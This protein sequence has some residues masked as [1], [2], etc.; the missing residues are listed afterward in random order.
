[1]SIAANKVDGIRCALVRSE[2]DAELARLHNNA[3]IIALGGRTTPDAVA[4][5]PS[6]S[7]VYLLKLKA[8]PCCSLFYVTS[9]GALFGAFRAAQGAYS[10]PPPVVLLGLTLPYSIV[11]KFLATQ[12]PADDS[13]A[14]HDRRVG[15]IMALEQC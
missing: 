6:L 13:G 9:N 8:D 14:R 3:N 12:R 1:M 2:S 4:L 10:A 5:G 11:D 7:G 15:K